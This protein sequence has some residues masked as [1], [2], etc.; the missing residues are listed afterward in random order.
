MPIYA[1]VVSGGNGFDCTIV[2]FS[3]ITLQTIRVGPA[4]V[5]VN[6]FK[7]DFSKS[8]RFHKLTTQKMTEKRFYDTASA[9]L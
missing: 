8:A 3:R 2:K 4:N 6:E 5:N 9:H 7:C 1:I